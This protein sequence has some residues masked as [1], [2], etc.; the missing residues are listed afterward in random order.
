MLPNPLLLDVVS[1]L[2][3]QTLAVL[4]LSNSSFNQFILTRLYE[5]PKRRVAV[6]VTSSVPPLNF[7]VRVGRRSV[8][9]SSEQLSTAVDTVFIQVLYFVYGLT[10]TD[11]LLEFLDGLK[12][13]LR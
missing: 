6:Y 11:E 10:F 5:L 1:F 3:G 8:T 2:R 7:K 12:L 9:L 13:K 4:R